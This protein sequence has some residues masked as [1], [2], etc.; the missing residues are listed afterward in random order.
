MIVISAFPEKSSFDAVENFVLNHNILSPMLP[1]FPTGMSLHICPSGSSFVQSAGLPCQTFPNPGSG[2]YGFGGV[3]PGRGGMVT[4]Q[5]WI[6]R[7]D[8][9]GLDPARERSVA[10]AKPHAAR[11]NA[12]ETVKNRL[13]PFVRRAHG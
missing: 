12:S 13:M 6:S 1:S 2:G 3:N 4:G 8:G 10:G 5:P 7:V 9:D 11:S